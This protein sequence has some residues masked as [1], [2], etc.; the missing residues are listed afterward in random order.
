V[1]ELDD[2]WVPVVPPRPMSP[3]RI[4]AVPE[5]VV[6]PAAPSSLLTE[7]PL[8]SS[9]VPDFSMDFSSLEPQEETKPEKRGPRNS[10]R[11]PESILVR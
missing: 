9:N 11:K 7:V 2:D 8:L 3:L 4:C 1:T 10:R 6:V 5:P